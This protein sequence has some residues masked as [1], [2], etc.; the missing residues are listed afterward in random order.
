MMALRNRKFA[1]MAIFVSAISLLVLSL[2]GCASNPVA[3]PTPSA[4]QTQMTDAQALV[5]FTAIV[6]SSLAKQNETGLTQTT[7]S[8]L[9]ETYLLVADKAAGKYRATEKNP[10][11]SFQLLS[12]PDAFVPAAA[13]LWLQLGATVSF[14]QGDYILTRLIEG[15]PTTYRFKVSE[16]LL[17][18]KSEQ[19]VDGTSASVL[20][21]EITADALLV[22]QAGEKIST[23]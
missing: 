19:S 3:T 5:E 23:N 17:I 20:Q 6:D 8:S 7:I 1:A 10:D 9:N 18:S 15:A 2:S 21:Y 13:K 16:G 4:T 14:D 12:E 11:G 22:L